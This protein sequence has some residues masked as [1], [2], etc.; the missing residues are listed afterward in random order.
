MSESIELLAALG[1]SPVA[2]SLLLHPGDQHLLY[3]LGS[4]VIIRHLTQNTQQFLV[5]HDAP[6]STLALSVTGKYL[7]SG[8]Q[9]VMGFP[10]PVL[11]WNLET[12]EVVARLNLHKGSVQ[13]IAISPNERFVYAFPINW[14]LTSSDMQICC[15]SWWT[16]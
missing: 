11:V 16:R 1:A 9:S 12:L 6:I 8:Q 13:A 2:N 5:G 4:N 10:A 7:A 3:A 14:H 15:H